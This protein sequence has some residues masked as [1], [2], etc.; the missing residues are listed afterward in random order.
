M[1]RSV[2]QRVQQASVSV[3]GDTVGRIGAGL[4]VLVA[5]LAGDGPADIA[6]TASKIR[7]IRLFADAD[8][9]MNRSLLEVGGAVLLVSQFTLAGDARKGR[10]PAFDRAAPPEV[11]RPIFDTLVD[12]V[13]EGGLTVA[14]GRFGA[15]MQLALVNDG[16]VTVLLDSQRQF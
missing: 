14:T 11:A 6:Y 9:R 1:M 8:G 16:P 15:S 10:R 4:V 13:R 2:L 5:V 3:D 7:D 12:R